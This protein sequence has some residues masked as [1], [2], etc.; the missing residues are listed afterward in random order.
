L[1]TSEFAY[2]TS[3][4]RKTN[5]KPHEIFGCVRSRQSNDHIPINEH[6]KAF[7]SKFGSHMHELHKRISG[8]VAHN[9]ANYKLRADIGKKI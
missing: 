9:N 8:K 5:K 4:N 7:E 6:Y 2:N 3:L 1:S